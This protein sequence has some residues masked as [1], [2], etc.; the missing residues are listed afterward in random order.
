MTI[1]TYTLALAL[2]TMSVCVD[3]SE[4]VETSSPVSA[5]Y[6]CGSEGGMTIIAATADFST[7]APGPA[8]DGYQRANRQA[9]VPM[10]GWAKRFS[11][12][13]ATAGNR[14]MRR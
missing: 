8:K 4:A 13:V 6:K 7:S 11:R 3:A 2:L 5:A 14:R 9:D 10:Q 1:R 12:G